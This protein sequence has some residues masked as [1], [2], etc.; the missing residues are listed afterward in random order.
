MILETFTHLK[1]NLKKDTAAFKSIKIAILSDSAS[2]LLTQAIKGYGVEN[3]VNYKIFEADYNQVD[4]QIFDPGSELYQYAPDYV[5]VVRG[6]EKLTKLFYKLSVEEKEIFASS[7]LKHTQDLLQSI[8]SRLKCKVI[9]T[10]YI[11]LN[12]SIFGNFASKT[13]ASFLYQAKKLNIQLMELSQER[14]NVF[15]IDVNALVTKFGYN[16]AFDPKIYYSADMAFSIDF[17]PVISKNIHD[18]IQAASGIFKKCVILDLDNTT[19]GGIIGDDGMDGIQIGDLGSG[20]IFSELQLWVKQLK[21]RG[22]IVAVCSKN[23]EE[24][25]KE[26]FISHPQMILRLEDIAVF[27]ANWSNKADNIRYIQSILN[28][29]FDSMVF[30]DDNPF[31]R[32]LVKKEIPEITVPGLPE[33]PAEYLL[34]LKDLNLFE[35]VSYTKE[36]ELRT[37]QYQEEAKRNILQKSFA[38]EDDFLASLD[39]LSEVKRFDNFTIPRVAQLSQRSNQFNLRTVR[40]LEEELVTMSES[41]DYLT[42]SFTLTDKYGD[43]GLIAFVVLKSLDAETVFIE[44]WVMSCRVLKRGMEEFTLSCIIEESKAL[45]FK[46]I[47]GEYIPTKKNGIVK[48]HYDLL[49]FSTQED[50][51]ILDLYNY[52]SNKLSF[53]KKV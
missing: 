8:D 36:D 3:Q 9:F 52:Q 51:Y 16:Q 12:D 10:S 49:G 42:L 46:T 37:I 24:I 44:N 15:L 31:E 7:Q 32:E 34:F 18:I 38:N 41:S 19:W 47:L 30:L 48:E 20:K 4:R 14:T 25:A 26:P 6:V 1:R 27:V 21:Q 40:Y 45:G 23:T 17:L 29:G 33:D 13:K 2:Q 5:I 11:E 28:I 35:T 50:Q 22:I 39:M 53:I 43:N